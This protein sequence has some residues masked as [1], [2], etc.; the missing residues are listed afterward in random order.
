MR[1]NII[2]L[3]FALI[4][5]YCTIDSI[6]AEW[7]L[8]PSFD[9]TPLRIIDTPEDTYFLVHQQ[10]YDKSK[11]GYDFP[12]L[13][14]FRYNK[15]ATDKGIT[16]LVHDV[17][18]TSADIRMADYSPKG[19]YLIIV[20][21]DGGI[22]LIDK[23]RHLT[24]VDKLK[25]YTIPGMA[26]VTSVSFE[27][28]TGDA[29]IGT[30][31]GYMHV[32]AGTFTVKAVKVFDRGI[33]R[34]CRFGDKLVALSGNAA[35]QSDTADPLTFNE[36]KQISSIASP[37][38]LLPLADNQFAFVYGEPG[39]NSPINRVLKLARYDDSSWR[40]SDLGQDF[41]Y[42]L[43]NNGTLVNRY[44]ANFIPNRDGYLIYSTSKAWQLY[45]P[46]NDEP[47]RFVSISLDSNPL[48]LGSW[49]FSN[50]WSYRDRGTFVPRHADFTM[51]SNATSAAATW[52]DMQD[53]IRPNAPAAFICTYMDY[54]PKYGLL[55][56]NHGVDWNFTYVGAVVPS[57]LSGLN[58]NKWN[59]YSQTYDIPYSIENNPDLKS[60]Y[61]EFYPLYSPKG[62]F[63][64]PLN[65]DK[66]WISSMFGGIMVMD[67][68]DVK[69]DVIRFGT[70]KDPFNGFPGFIPAMPDGAWGSHCA[71]APVRCDP[72]NRLWTI[73][74]ARGQNRV[75]HLKYMNV[76]RVN[77]FYVKPVESI[78]EEKAWN[79]IILPYAGDASS[80]CSVLPLFH[81]RNRNKLIINTGIYEDK[82]ILYDHKGTLEDT[83]DDIYYEIH[84][85]VSPSG[86]KSE[87]Y[88]I[89][90]VVEDPI[91]GK[92]L[93]S[94]MNKTFTFFSD[95]DKIEGGIIGNYNNVLGDEFKNQI[96]STIQINSIIY[97]EYDRMWIATNNLGLIGFSKKDKNIVVYNTENSSLL[98]DC[99]YGL[100]WDT[101]TQSLMISTKLGMVQLFP[102]IASEFKTKKILSVVPNKISPDF[103]GNVNI[104]NIPY[105]SQI[106]IK[107]KYGKVVNILENENFSNIQ[108]N[109]CDS[110]GK[111]IES[112]IYTICIKDNNSVELIM[113]GSR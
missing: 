113:M 91:S 26:Q 90:N 104:N 41:F 15:N 100:G 106:I 11:V 94:T 112:G 83:N 109:L 60:K 89:F 2:K 1:K 103:N 18:L 57:L 61:T 80:K 76:D 75:L 3:V 64:D 54:S 70:E 99:V 30:D 55:A 5:S 6:G 19:E 33:A 101:S 110:T 98:S 69:K 48:S 81:E 50:F 31:A 40:I 78:S 7:K 47:A 49:D 8:H 27:P 77:D 43:P 51:D 82:I 97:D 42:S 71:F 4:L 66:V 17:Q 68:S 88:E 32:E 25:R 67:L 102:D 96:P 53:P 12:S 16:P 63:V 29:W 23:N 105:F 65:P 56:I 36:F 62:V 79:T 111:K 28:S 39:N 44:E 86:E 87:F 72:G 92:I 14:L 37:S 20:Y 108:W 73:F 95:A 34:I 84:S 45:A 10:I 38:V 74:Y 107:D 22:D 59:I 58:N 21:N 52:T 46:E 35:W 93:V 85:I 9:R 24:H 13:T